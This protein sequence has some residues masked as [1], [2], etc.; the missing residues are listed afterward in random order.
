[1]LHVACFAGGRLAEI[2]VLRAIIHDLPT[3]ST[4][5]DDFM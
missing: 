1:M 3:E 4:E 5:A 2:L